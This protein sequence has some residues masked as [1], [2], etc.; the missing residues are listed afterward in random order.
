MCF[1]PRAKLGLLL[2]FLVAVSTTPAQARTAFAVYALLLVT[3][4]LVAR[5]SLAS[6]LVRSAVVLPLS[7]LAALLTWLSGDPLRALGLI[8]KSLLSVFATVLM[9]STTPI[10]RIAAALE[11]ARVPRVVVL[12]IQFL[13]RYLFVIADEARYLQRAAR[14]RSGHRGSVRAQ[15]TAAAGS[16]GV[17]FAKSWQRADGI[18]NAMLARGFHGV[19]P[20]FDRRQ[21][22]MKDGALVGGGALTLA[23]VRLLL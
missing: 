6:L 21:F 15:F 2:L 17:L 20:Q 14:S 11:W 10:A 16:L 19:F 9:T 12:V 8:E 4:A 3:A 1:D 7:G 22:T 23:L 5:V 18:Y 13:H